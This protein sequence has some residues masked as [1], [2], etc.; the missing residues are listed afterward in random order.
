MLS[1]EHEVE[2]QFARLFSRDDWALF[3]KTQITTSCEQYSCAL[4]TSSFR[5]S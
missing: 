1:V 4:V 3:K 2:R 5:A